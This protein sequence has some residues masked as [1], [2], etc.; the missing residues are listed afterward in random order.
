MSCVSRVCLILVCVGVAVLPFQVSADQIP[1]GPIEKVVHLG[2]YK[3][4]V[5]FKVNISTKDDQIM[6]PAGVCSGR[7]VGRFELGFSAITDRRDDLES[8]PPVLMTNTER[9]KFSGSLA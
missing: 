6:R 8:A 1:G 9:T 3:G 5:Y 4:A 7:K 2:F